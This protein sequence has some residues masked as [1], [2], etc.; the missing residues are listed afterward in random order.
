[1]EGFV[2]S[3]IKIVKIEKK[4]TMGKGSWGVTALQ[5]EITSWVHAFDR[6]MQDNSD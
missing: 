1:M 6:N 4:A 3:V 5:A 2:I